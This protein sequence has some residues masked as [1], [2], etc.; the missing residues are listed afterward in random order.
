[1][2]WDFVLPAEVLHR[3]PAQDETERGWTFF[4]LTHVWGKQLVVYL[5]N[6]GADH[7]Y[8]R[9]SLLPETVSLRE[10]VRGDIQQSLQEVGELS[11]ADLA[12]TWGQGDQP[13]WWVQKDV[14]EL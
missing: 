7:S 10:Q 2:R 4:P 13:L 3:K 11:S 1:M 9:G 14:Y 12:A 6:Q 8:W 5:H